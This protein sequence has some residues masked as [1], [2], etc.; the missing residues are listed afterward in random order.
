MDLIK[1]KISMK[2]VTSSHCKTIQLTVFEFLLESDMQT[3]NN[4]CNFALF[5]TVDE[6]RSLHFV[7]E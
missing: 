6:K 2:Q 3:F 1:N 4:P 7:P 5:R